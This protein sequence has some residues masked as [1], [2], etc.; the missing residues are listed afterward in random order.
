M[1]LVSG[2]EFAQARPGELQDRPLR[3]PWWHETGSAGSTTA[4]RNGFITHFSDPSPV[5]S[6]GPGELH[7]SSKASRTEPSGSPR[8]P[9]LNA[10][11]AVLRFAEPADPTEVQLQP[12]TWLVR[13]DRLRP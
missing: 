13:A 6:T 3:G 5:L 1:A 7:A 9:H 4:A 10:P 11:D 12:G 8:A 2:A